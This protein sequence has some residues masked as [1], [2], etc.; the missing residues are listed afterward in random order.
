MNEYTSP[1]QSSSGLDPRLA[2][3]LAY[4]IPPLT[5][6]IFLLVEKSDRTVRWHAAQSTVFGIVWIILWFALTIVATVISAVV[7]FFGLLAWPIWVVVWIGGL[8]LW[9][10]CLIKG[11]SGEV[12][13]MP[14]LAEYADK[15]LASQGGNAS[16]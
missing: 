8:I 9:V 1:P 3:L 7:P 13:R 6:I 5:G 10:V 12:W 14:V 2:G 4:L 16:P 15:I 11:Y